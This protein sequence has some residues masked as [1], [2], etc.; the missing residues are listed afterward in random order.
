V[1]AALITQARARRARAVALCRS[2][3]YEALAIGFRR[4]TEVTRTRLLTEDAAAALAEAA[5][6]LDEEVPLPSAGTQDGLAA[7]VKA[8][9][10]SDDGRTLESLLLSHL[11]LFGHTVRGPVPPYET[12]YGEDTLFQKP[13][14]MSDVAGF[15]SAFGLVLN[16]AK[17]ERI[18]HVSCELE[19][20]AFLSRKEAHAIE[21]EN[22]SMLEET[23]RAARLFLRDHLGRFLPSF[24][25]RVE[26]VDKDGFYG[27][28]ARLGID[29]LEKE[30]ER[31]DAPAG[32]EMLRL[33]LPIDDG[34]PLACG[35]PDGCGVPGPCG[36][37]E[38]GADDSTSR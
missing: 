27:R 6:V 13:Q 12:E 31:Y 10:R 2:L 36:A 17:H 38:D 22:A 21:T 8:L 25:R 19:F 23:R 15:L 16:T 26:G 5:A 20:L 34:A 35:A 37:P 33:R 9:A 4:P 14:E 11:K 30:C 7:L 3:L 29:F 28:L 32:P 18:D 24:A 1:N